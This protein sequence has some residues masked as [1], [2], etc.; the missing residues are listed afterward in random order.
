[1]SVP[2]ADFAARLAAGDYGAIWKWAGG[3]FGF[4]WGAAQFLSWV[5]R[6]SAADRS[7]IALSNRDAEA[8]DA[9]R[10]MVTVL[11]E[12]ITVIKLDLHAAHKEITELRNQLIAERDA[13][14]D[15]QR[16]FNDLATKA[17][18]LGLIPDG[19]LAKT[20]YDGI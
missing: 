3:F 15:L 7:A 12:Q 6:R 8:A 20:F 17:F 16:R 1:M 2:E 5:M 14:R 18:S 4:L 9:Q 10:D 13:R 11:R 19:D